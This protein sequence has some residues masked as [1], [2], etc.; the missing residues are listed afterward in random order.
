MLFGRS[1]SRSFSDFDLVVSVGVGWGLYLFA[2]TFC[3]LLPK[4]LFVAMGMVY[5]SDRF[6]GAAVGA[7]Y[8]DNVGGV[9]SE[10]SKG[11]QH[12][13]GSLV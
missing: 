3:F 13:S 1:V 12:Q 5:V 8:C 2:G 9:L 6:F 7:S 10:L 11:S 4:V